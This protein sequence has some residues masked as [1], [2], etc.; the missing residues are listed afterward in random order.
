MQRVKSLWK[1]ADPHCGPSTRGAWLQRLGLPC[2]E[3]VVL[4]LKHTS[5]QSR[6]YCF[7]FSIFLKNN[8]FINFLL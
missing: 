1:G 8:S 7:A 6:F 4:P 5:L 2:P 3:G